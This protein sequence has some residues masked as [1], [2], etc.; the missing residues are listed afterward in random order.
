MAV[1]QM[2]ALLET[3]VHFGHR[4]RR[5]NPKMKPYIF[6]ERNGIHII[7]LQQTMAAVET[8]Y[9]LVRDTVS[10]GEPV[11][12]VGTKRQAQ[13]AINQQALRC[14]Q[15]YIT[16][17]WLGGT[18]TNWR[19]IRQR[20]ETLAS[21]EGRR[22]RGEF[23]RLIK[24]EALMLTRE[25]E[26]LNLR[27]GGI[28]DMKRLPG[29]IFVVDVRHEVT[30]IRESNSLDIPVIAMVDT[31]CDPDSID[32][33]IPS[34]DDAIR[35]IK[36]IVTKMAD[37]ALEGAAMHKET[38]PAE[39]AE[40]GAAEAEE[41]YLGEATLAK[42]RSGALDFEDEMSDEFEGGEPDEEGL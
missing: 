35:A 23:D 3:G 29:A 41:K 19:T 5:W 14:G 40:E 42:I 26:K 36:L 16:H 32:Y 9:N 34:N 12:F 17:R 18:L 4:T 39:V 20:I 13:E 15:P 38:M 31:N 8:A 7:D 28:K 6:T 22:D 30:A 11:L 37:A 2:K 10:R 1:I 33:V 21:L 27:L 25:I 24:K